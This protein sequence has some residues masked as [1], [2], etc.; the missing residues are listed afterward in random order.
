[1]KKTSK[2]NMVL[3]SVSAAMVASIVAPVASHA[4][5]SYAKE[6]RLKVA[7]YN[8]FV[9][10]NYT[11]AKKASELKNQAQKAVAKVKNI[12]TKKELQAIIDVKT[13]KIASTLKTLEAAKKA[14]GKFTSFKVHKLTDKETADQL[15]K[16]ALEAVAKIEDA[17]YKKVYKDQITAKYNKVLQSIA[18]LKATEVK[19]VTVVNNHTIKVEFTRA[20]SKTTGEDI[21]NYK[22]ADNGLK[23]TKAVVTGNKV[24]LTISGVATHAEQ[25]PATTLTIS[26]VT[27]MKNLKVTDATVAI[28]FKDKKAPAFKT[29]KTQDTD[30]NGKIDTLVVTFSEP[31]T[32]VDKTDFL[33][34][35]YYIS[36]VTTEGAVSF[37]R[38]KESAV[39]DLTATPQIV[40]I[41]Q[42]SDAVGNKTSF[43]KPF[44]STVGTALVK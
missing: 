28:A 19:R 23:V 7:V 13:E 39:T 3:A 10:T 21:N 26:N 6:A 25:A 27:D 32:G 17:A 5:V 11:H 2:K 18:N 41:D 37:I 24:T 35:G 42:I 20:I 29:V 40:L 34:E 12:N 16:E 8:N 22:L 31:V 30:N 44:T 14:V 33:V 4:A 9:V 1:M 15:M 36:S 43:L 38:V